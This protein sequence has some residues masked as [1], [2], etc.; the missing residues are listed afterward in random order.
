MPFATYFAQSGQAGIR[1][2]FV[3]HDSPADPMASITASFRYLS[4]LDY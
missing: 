2:Y 1:H 4:T 3:E